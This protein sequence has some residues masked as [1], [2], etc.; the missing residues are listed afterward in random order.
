MTTDG[1]KR[2][3]LYEADGEPPHALILAPGVDAKDSADEGRWRG[4]A[5]C[6]RSDDCP[7]WWCD[8]DLEALQGA[9]PLACPTCTERSG[10]PDLTWRTAIIE[11][12]QCGSWASYSVLDPSDTWPKRVP[13]CRCRNRLKTPVVGTHLVH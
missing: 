13:C 8:F 2:V 5:A 4:M 9:A 12:G 10:W 11:C 6:D 1:E 3:W 7:V